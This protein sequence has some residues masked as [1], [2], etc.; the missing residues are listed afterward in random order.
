MDIVLDLAKTLHNLLIAPAL[1]GTTQI[2]A[3]DLPEN[4][5][6][7][8]FGIVA[9]KVCPQAANIAAAQ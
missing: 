3:Y 9:W 5:S 6:V 8:P 7:R 4:P 2:D 1:D